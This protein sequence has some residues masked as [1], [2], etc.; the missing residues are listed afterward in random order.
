MDKQVQIL[1]KEARKKKGL[2]QSDIAEKMEVKPS[3]I[4]NWENGISEP[5]IDSFVQYCQICGVDFA[6]LLTKVYGNPA[7]QMQDFKCTTAEMEMIRMF[8]T[9][10]AGGQR[11]TL[12][13]LR[14]EY[15]DALASFGEDSQSVPSTG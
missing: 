6:E 5:D 7:E 13:H 15:E 4:S 10:D 11:R 3:T 14:G 2:K 1:M 9:L 8:R 12:R